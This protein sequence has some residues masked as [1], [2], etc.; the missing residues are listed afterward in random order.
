[1]SRA[2]MMLKPMATYTTTFPCGER[3][4]PQPRKPKTTLPSGGPSH[5][6]TQHFA[7][8]LSTTN[9]PISFRRGPGLASSNGTRFRP[10]SS[11][12]GKHT[13]SRCQRRKQRER[14][15]APVV[16]SPSYS[17]HLWRWH[18]CVWLDQDRSISS[19]DDL[20]TQRMKERVDAVAFT[21]VTSS[22]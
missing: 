15:T 9:N 22:P 4:L 21:S 19:A 6:K 14:T 17:A 13:A 5:C 1:M 16:P 18:R 20:T 11:L 12:Q 8:G 3:C 10:G 2:Q 7:P